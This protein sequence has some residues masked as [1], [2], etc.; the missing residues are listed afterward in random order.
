MP[1]YFLEL[2]YKGTAYK[3]FQAQPNIITVQGEVEKVFRTLLGYE[4]K[5][6]TSSRTDAGVHAKQNFFHFD[7]DAILSSKILYNLNAM[8]PKDI[9]LINLY[10]TDEQYHSRFHATSRAYQYYLYSNKNPFFTDTAYYY[11]FKLDRERLQAAADVL[12]EYRYFASF[13]K[14]NTQV[15]TFLCEIKESFWFDEGEC[16]VYRV[17]GNRFLRG[18]VRALVG[19]MLKVG[20]GAI[21]IEQFR[22]VIE[23]KDCTNADFSTPGHG[24]F[25]ME[26]NYPQGI[27]G[28]KTFFEKK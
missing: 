18:M 6:I 27:F 15:H 22:G 11:P 26:V 28:E 10:E 20:R 8:L 5:L 17:K 14:R 12:K 7:N 19:T 25:L 23:S 1:R 21:S 16:L 4:V 13:S 9:A 24:L 2:S 3:G